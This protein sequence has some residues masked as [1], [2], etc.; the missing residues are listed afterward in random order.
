M[1]KTKHL[2]IKDWEA[3]DKPREKFISKGAEY[4]S[5]AELITILLGTGTA[6]S[7][8]LDLAKRLLNKHPNLDDLANLHFKY[9]TEINGI[10][11]AKAIT[12]AAAFELARR[13]NLH[14]N[15]LRPKFQSP[16]DVGN[17]YCAKFEHLKHE[18]FW[19]VML[20]T[21]NKIIGEEK[22]SQGILNKSLVHP[23]EVFKMAI[24]NSAFSI[25]LVHN[26]P[27]GNLEASKSDILITEKLIQSG[28]IVEIRV[29][30]HIIVAGKNFISMKKEAL[31]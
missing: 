18:E 9:Y 22:I 5:D 30:D 4:L 12:L 19:I 6:N 26:H 16:E 25:I 28:E 2:S 13:I 10:G 1:E 17:Y 15:P 3:S 31:I 29:L 23:R 20:D 7:S 24:K 14:K 11:P 21:Q 8:A 27:S